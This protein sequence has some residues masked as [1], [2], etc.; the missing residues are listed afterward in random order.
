MTGGITYLTETPGSGT[1]PYSYVWKFD[2][3]VISGATN[4]VLPVQISPGSVG[5][6]TVVVS[7]QAGT[8]AN[9]PFVIS[10]PIS[11][12]PDQLIYEPFDS[13][14]QMG[15]PSAPYTWQGVT[16]LFDQATGEPAYWF[17]SSGSRI[18]MV[19]SPN[20]FP[21]FTVIA[22]RVIRGRAWPEQRQLHVSG[23]QFV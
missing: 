4:S 13:Y 14:G 8:V 16:N 10:G 12:V 19:I 17:H 11:V 15:G 22:L 20:D 3:T 7:N 5:S 21:S 6:Y 18:S 2:G 1:P 9:T 23:S